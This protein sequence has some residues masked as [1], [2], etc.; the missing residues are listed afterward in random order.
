MDFMMGLP[1]ALRKYDAIWVI[2]GRLTKSAHFLPVQL[3]YKLERF[4]KLYIVEIVKLH[5]I[6]VS[7]V[8]DRDP[9]FTSRL[10]L[11]LHQAMGT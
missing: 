6:S 2:A 10:W 9:R 4:A 5:G 8:L 1:R 3:T 11:K 7:I